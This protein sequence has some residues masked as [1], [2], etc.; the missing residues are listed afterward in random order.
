MFQNL[1][2]KDFILAINLEIQA[3]FS[4]LVLNLGRDLGEQHQ[5]VSPIK[6]Q[7]LIARSGRSQIVSNSP[8][9]NA[10][11]RYLRPTATGPRR[12][13]RTQQLFLSHCQDLSQPFGNKCLQYLEMETVAAKNLNIS[14]FLMLKTLPR[15][16]RFGLRQLQVQG[17]YPHRSQ[18]KW[19][20][21]PCWI[22]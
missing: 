15:L 8:K 1:N 2:D 10:M 11:S 5:T 20:V 19:S 4:T 9:I 17:I 12:L 13:N 22:D 3:S 18:T 21:P 6:F 14:S 16:W 7:A